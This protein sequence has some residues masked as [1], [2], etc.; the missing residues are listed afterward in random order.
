MTKYYPNLIN[1]HETGKWINYKNEFCDVT[2]KITMILVH[3]TI[4]KIQFLRE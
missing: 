4:V 2:H 3:A 1:I